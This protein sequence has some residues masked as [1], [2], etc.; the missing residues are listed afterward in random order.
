MFVSN[1]GRVPIKPW[2][3]I[4]SVVVWKMTELKVSRFVGFTR[5]SRSGGGSVVRL[6]F[7]VAEPLLDKNLRR[8]DGLRWRDK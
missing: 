4:S 8:E 2:L 7:A 3:P 6:H 5:F 1:G